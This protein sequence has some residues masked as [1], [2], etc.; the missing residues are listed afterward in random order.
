MIA[1]QTVGRSPAGRGYPV[2]QPTILALMR[3]GDHRGAIVHLQS[4]LAK[5]SYDAD[6]IADMASCYWRLGDE[7][8][9]I[10]LMEVVVDGNAA[11][12][13]ALARLGAMYLST[14]N[15]EGAAALLERAL[16]LRPGFVSALVALNQIHPYP[17]DGHRIRTVRKLLR[18]ERTTRQEKSLLHGIL[19]R[20]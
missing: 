12:A 7:A 9:A 18:S 2:M 16:A 10:R 17:K 20:T 3:K 15:A 4:A 5:L 11:T 1:H 19:G 13:E 14:G 8:A 6:L